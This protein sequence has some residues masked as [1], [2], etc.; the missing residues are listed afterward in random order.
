MFDI[1]SAGLLVFLLLRI[2]INLNK[3]GKVFS[4]FRFFDC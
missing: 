1:F 2:L 4:G 3:R